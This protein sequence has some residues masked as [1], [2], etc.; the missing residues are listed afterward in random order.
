MVDTADGSKSAHKHRWRAKIFSKDDDAPPKDP[1]PKTQSSF[2]LDDDINAFLKPSTERAQAHKDAAAA[3]LQTTNTPRI[4]TS[5]AQR[6]PSA[7]D[8]VNSGL[9]RSPGIGGLKTGGGRK[10]GLTVS[11]VRTQPDVIGE[12]GD[13]CEDPSIEV[14]KRKKAHS[15]SD[16]DKMSSQ[17]HQD[18]ISLGARTSSGGESFNQDAAK[19]GVVTRT[20]T[21]GGELSPP[22]RQKLEIGSINT[23]AQPPEPPEPR[24]GSMGLGERPKPLSRVPT[25]F[26]P[27]QVET[28]VSLRRPSVDSVQSHESENTSPVATR[29][30]PDLPPTKEEDEDFAPAPLKRSQTGFSTLGGDLEEEPPT[31]PSPLARFTSNEWD[32]SP[33]EAKSLLVEQYLKSEPKDRLIH[34][35]R[36]EEGKALHEAAHNRQDSDSSNA[37]LQA[38]SVH[39]NAFQVGT[40]PSA[41]NTLA[42]GKTPPRLLSRDPSYQTVGSPKQQY[43]PLQSAL[44]AEDPYR[45]RARRPSSPARS[46]M[47]PGTSPLDTD[48]RPPSAGSSA[49]SGVSASR[50]VAQF[51]AA[52]E[53]S[54]AT[55]TGS[56]QSE[57]QA[58]SAI[59]QTSIAPTPPQYERAAPIPSPPTDR[60]PQHQLPPKP[61]P[62]SQ[63]PVSVPPPQSNAA[64]AKPAGTLGRSDTKMQ[65]NAAY[66]DFATRIEHMRGVFELTAQLNGQINSHSPMEWIRVAIWWF[67]KGRSGMEIQIR[68]RPKTAEPQP[69]RLTQPHVDLAKAWWILNEVLHEHPGLGRYAGE[70]TDMQARSARE[71]G[72]NSNADVYEARD[73]IIASMKLLLGSMQ[74]NQSMPPTQALL[75]GQL[76]QDLWEKYPRFAP[77]VGSVLAGTAGKSVLASGP[78]QLNAAVQIPISDTK[79][80]FTYFRMFVNVSVST[81]DPN[82]DR[83]PL[84]AVV[85]VLRSREDFKVKIV[86]CS[87]TELINL[88]VGANPDAGPTWRD[89]HWRS[90]GQGF[91]V[92][93][94]HGY[95]LNVETAETDFRTL[96][97][98]VDHTNRVEST[99][100]ERADERLSSKIYLREAAYKDP[101]NP[102]AFP[103]DRVRPCKLYVFEKFDL[104]SEGTGK[105]KL[106]R[107]YRVVLVTHPM[108]RTVSFASHE[109]GTRQDPLNFSYGTEPDQAPSMAFRIREE[110]PDNKSKF[111]N[112]HIVFNDP[113]ERNHIFGLLTSMNIG[114]GEMIFAQVPLKSYSIESADVVEGF[115]QGWKEVLK[116]LQW[117]EAKTYN[118]DPEEA[119]LESAPTVMSESLRI[120]CRHSAGVFSDRMNLDTG[121]LLVRLPIDG[122]PEL[123]LLRNPQQ[124]MAVAVDF[125]RTEQDVPQALAEMLQ[126]LMRTSTIRKLTFNSFND[127]HAFQFAVTGFNVIFDGIAS[128][129]SISRR[130]M[131]VPIYKQWTASQIRIQIVEQDNIIQLLAFFENFSHADAMN[132]QLRVTDTYEK[133]D[134][135]GKP[136]LRMVDCKFALPV[137]ERKGEGKMGK[138]EG[139]LTGWAGT[140]RRFVCLDQIEYPGEHDDVLIGFDSVETRD[141]FAEAL[142]SAT[143]KQKFSIRRKI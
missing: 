100:R 104:S 138:E 82:N 32:D 84:P 136:S 142:P 116:R 80:D 107:G 6:W 56:A 134:K 46:P 28:P 92:Q 11:F 20:L 34:D 42:A 112:M 5:A 131:V 114:T 85:T 121:E 10:K 69:E 22:L 72:D 87:Q 55:T 96:W 76:H 135:G 90:K 89:V 113:K 140:K 1:K 38:S 19:R 130:R 77:D 54:S 17:T 41:V 108:V 48:P 30:V 9:G 49:Y 59:S 3:F 139:R 88:T 61:P 129:F 4:D 26:D 101:A 58:F 65:G 117:V 67:L 124:D 12:G 64:P 120:L 118:Q 123:T 110:M 53:P 27:Q 50:K 103:P 13:E 78:Q 102:S 33:T 127:L 133:S 132:F 95:I 99:I 97:N 105:R 81:D 7:S 23:H 47:P 75:Q 91:S 137:E 71:A 143:T 126:T 57:R 63:S 73:A 98:I 79:A 94:R 66:K 25:G 125:T 44:E 115:S 8:I 86:I 122:S 39:S 16:V 15:L 35:M 24:L 128:T 111:C 60:Q 14:Y 37:S 70:P 31:L 45:S 83:Q 141:R 29:K 2:K 93:L 119:G 18:D 109:F 43:N 62:H 51:N 40:P 52:P 21:S 74:R 106:H 36:A 68:S